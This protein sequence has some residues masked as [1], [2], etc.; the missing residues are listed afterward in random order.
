MRWI[1][2]GIIGLLGG[3]VSGL[4]GVGG[5]VLFVPLLVL[6]LHTNLHLA[7]GTSLAAIVPTALVGAIRHFSAGSVDLRVA[8]ALALC[9][10]GGAWLGAELSLRLDLILLRRLFALFLF[11]IAFRLFFTA[12]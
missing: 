11:F 9:A 4:F 5:G 3:F 10:M 8:L 7:I 12:A 6:F 2:I 1:G